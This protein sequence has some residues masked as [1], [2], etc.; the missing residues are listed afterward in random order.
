MGHTHPPAHLSPTQALVYPTGS[1]TSL[2]RC[3][4]SS[5][6]R[7]SALLLLS[8]E[9]VVGTWQGSGSQG[10]HWAA[11]A[12]PALTS[13]SLKGLLIHFILIEHPLGIWHC[14]GHCGKLSWTTPQ[15]SCCRSS[16]PDWCLSSAKEAVALPQVWEE[17]S[18]AIFPTP[19]KD[20]D[21]L[22]VK[23]SLP[24]H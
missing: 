8:Q 3:R 23:H 6:F 20:K 18:T 22:L 16:P 10:E 4:F 12:R 1:Y 7:T 15:K 14:A 19:I 21:W 24:L 17:S 9:G 11:L 2:R 13:R 5:S